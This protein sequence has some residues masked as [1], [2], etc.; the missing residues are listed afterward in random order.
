M[1]MQP[2]H[3]PE[4]E[5]YD[6]IH[7]DLATIEWMDQLGYSEVWLGEHLAAPWEPFPA[8][9]LILAQAIDRTSQIKLC[10]GAYVATFYHPAAL[11]HRIMQLDHMLQGRFMCGIAAGGIPTDFP[12]VGI[13]PTT[14]KNREMMRESIE[15]MLKIW[16]EIDGPWEYKG[17]Y[18]T[19]RNPEPVGGYRPHLRPY[20]KPH[21]PIG[22]ASISPN[23]SSIRY[24]GT[25]GFLPMSL[26]FNVDYL[27]DH[28]TQ[29]SEGAAEAGRPVDRRDWRL[30]REIH[31]AE[32]DKEAKEWVRNSYMAAHWNAENLPFLGSVGWLQYLKHDPAVPD[33]AIDIDYLIDNLWLV[34]SPETVTKK[35]VD[36]YERTGGFGTILYQKY[37][38]GDDREAYFRSLQLFAEEVVPAFEGSGTEQ[39]VR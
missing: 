33:D 31:V 13:D 7:Q 26:T 16:T 20:Q 39:V 38:F 12:L 14:G 6:G 22:I 11:A 1:F 18:W 32:S 35:L 30:V 23:S 9:D 29:V 25:M 4:R 17:R 21:P 36:V 19:V 10:S 15:I 2:S 5:T 37:D 27:K 28:W 8:C 24:A 34:G 3:P